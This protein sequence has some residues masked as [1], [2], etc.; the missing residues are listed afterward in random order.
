MGKGAVIGAGATLAED[1]RIWPEKQVPAGAHV[2]VSVA[3]SETLRAR[4]FDEE[5]SLTG[6]ADTDL[7]PEYC[8]RFGLAVSGCL[9]GE[10]GVSGAGGQA[11][12]ACMLAF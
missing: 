11:A 6:T 1:V 4:T 7:T 9:T 5:G 2:E 10:I 12:K 3:G 8:L